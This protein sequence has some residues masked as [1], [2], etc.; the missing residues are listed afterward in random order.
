MPSNIE[1][2]A[3]LPDPEATRA[4]AAA[5]S[6]TPPETLRQRDT[7]F[8][9]GTGRLKLRQVDTGGAELIFYERPDVPGVKQSTYEITPVADAD[10]LRAVL[11]SALGVTQVVEKTRTLYLVGQTRVH[12]DS[13]DGLGEFLELEVVLRPGQTAADGE[14]I[15]AGLMEPLGIREADLC[16]GAYADMIGDAASRPTAAVSR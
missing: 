16:S 11:S 13:V 7:F 12:L 1:I 15:A 5:I 4:A 8:P 10:S 6:D 2:K 3:R 9:C 14:A